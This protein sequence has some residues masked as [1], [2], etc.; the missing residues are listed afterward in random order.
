MRLPNIKIPNIILNDDLICEVTIYSK[1]TNIDGHQERIGKTKKYNCTYSTCNK[2]AYS[3]ERIE[4]VANG[5][6]K[7][8]GDIIGDDKEYFGGIVKIFGINHN[9]ISIEKYRNLFDPN[10]VDYTEITV[11]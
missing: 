9:I 8:N 2:V 10:T 7:I 11:E 3:L 6:V 5:I 4:T 1:G